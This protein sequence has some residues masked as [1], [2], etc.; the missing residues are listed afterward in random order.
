VTQFR[1]RRV[2]LPLNTPASP[3]LNDDVQWLANVPNVFQA[4]ADPEGTH[5]FAQAPQWQHRPGHPSFAYWES[6]LF[7]L[8]HSFG[9]RSPA[10]GLK[11]WHDAGRPCDDDRLALIDQ[12]WFGDG[13]MRWFEAWVQHHAFRPTGE[14][15][16]PALPLPI[17]ETE[18]RSLNEALRH[19]IDNL[20][21]PAGDSDGLHLIGHLSGWVADDV[22]S[23]PET[24]NE[25]ILDSDGG[26]RGVLFTE[27]VVS[28]RAFLHGAAALRHEH[29]SGRSWR[30]DVIC[31]QIGWLGTYRRSRVTGY[32]FAGKHS[33]HRAGHPNQQT[34]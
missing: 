15:D 23:N 5:D 6:L 28:F 21:L 8:V 4:L 18:L 12:T 25:L 24:H 17:P 27:S 9:W 11:W 10:L 20:H 22:L 3:H 26:P 32:W 7:L 19:L 31:K 30:I 33:I 1:L 14:Q 29:P 34:P 16:S 2:K 13:F